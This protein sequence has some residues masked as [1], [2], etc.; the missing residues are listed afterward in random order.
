MQTGF[1]AGVPEKHETLVTGSELEEVSMI[2]AT[3]AISNIGIQDAPS[4]GE[5]GS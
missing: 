3:N 4:G 2:A 1:T 5:C